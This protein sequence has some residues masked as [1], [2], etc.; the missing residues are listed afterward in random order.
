VPDIPADLRYG[1]DH[2]WVRRGT[3]G[4][5]TRVGLTDFAQTSLG[6][7]VDVSLPRIGEAVSAGDPCGDVESTKSDS[8]LIAPV[9]GA[10][11]TLNGALAASPELVNS[12]PYGQGWLFELELDPAT[13]D[14]QLGVLLDAKA[15]G[16][17]TGG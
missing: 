7:I 17:L 8:D 15:Y 10:V 4:S 2:L 13:A 1:H 9:S 3:G 5:L 16:D 14:Q 12:D 6:D 11:R